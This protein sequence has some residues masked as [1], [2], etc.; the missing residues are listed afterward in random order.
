MVKREKT[1]KWFT[2]G[3]EQM[4]TFN[5]LLMITNILLTFILLV[6]AFIALMIYAI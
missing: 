4:Q 6:L 2:E 1:P 5:R 3:L